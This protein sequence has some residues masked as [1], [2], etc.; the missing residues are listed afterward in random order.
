MCIRESTEGLH[1]LAR[2]GFEEDNPEVAEWLK[3]LKLDD[4]QYGTLE[5]L[6]VNEYG[7]GKELEAVQEWLDKNPDVVEDI[8]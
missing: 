2:D 6:V 4:E 1:W 8:K 5:D 7:E 3:G